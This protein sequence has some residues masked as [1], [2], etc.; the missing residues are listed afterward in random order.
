M[1]LICIHCAIKAFLDGTAVEARE[2]TVE[3]HMIRC[4]PGPYAEVMRERRELERRL[5]EK[6]GWGDDIEG[7]SGQAKGRRSTS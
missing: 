1:K 3:E 6:E 7:D 5:S 4:H 2:E